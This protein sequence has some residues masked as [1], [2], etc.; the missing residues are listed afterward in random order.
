MN[1]WTAS[2]MRTTAFAMSGEQF[3]LIIIITL[4]ILTLCPNETASHR[5]LGDAAMS[6]ILP[7]RKLCQNRS[8]LADSAKGKLSIDCIASQVSAGS[9]M[10]N[11]VACGMMFCHGCLRLSK[12]HHMKAAPGL[13]HTCAQP[14]AQHL[15]DTPW[16]SSGVGL[17]ETTFRQRGSGPVTENE[18]SFDPY[19][20]CTDTSHLLSSTSPSVGRLA[21]PHP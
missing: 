4:Y 8:A 19:Q 3:K 11:D 21:S 20:S 13:R 14:W 1:T 6:S 10:Q 5:P 16:C 17:N 7:G 18:P 9:R 2:S 12:N 15:G